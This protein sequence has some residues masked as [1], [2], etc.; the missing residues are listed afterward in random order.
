M[1]YKIPINPHCK[2][3]MNAFAFLCFQV[4]YFHQDLQNPNKPSLQMEN[5]RCRV[6]HFLL[7]FPY[8]SKLL[9]GLE[10]KND[11][12]FAESFSI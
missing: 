8:K 6:P 7:P 9:T 12:A 3:K 10:I 11:S 2:W 4:I 1:I 5:E